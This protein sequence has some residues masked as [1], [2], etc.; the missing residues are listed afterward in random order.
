MLRVTGTFDT[1]VADPEKSKIC[2]MVINTNDLLFTNSDFTDGGVEIEEY[3]CT[4]NDLTYGDTPS[5]RLTFSVFG[6]GIPDGYSFFTSDTGNPII[7]MFGVE[8]ASA[9]YTFGSG[10]L[11]HI[12]VNDNGTTRVV[13]GKTDGLYYNG[14]KIDNGVYNTLLCNNAGNFLALPQTPDPV[15]PQYALVDFDGN[16]TDIT[17]NDLNA[18]MIRKFANGASWS[19]TDGNEAK[20]WADGSVVTYEL[21]SGGWFDCEIKNVS[22]TYVGNVYTFSDL[23]GIMSRNDDVTYYTYTP[24]QVVAYLD[25]EDA[26]KFP[27]V[28]YPMTLTTL[29]D[30]LNY[31][32]PESIIVD[33]L[34]YENLDAAT[35]TALKNRFNNISFASNPFHGRSI[36]FRQIL[37]WIGQITRTVA[38][39]SRASGGAI[40]PRWISI[41]GDRQHQQWDIAETVNY[42]NIASS[43]ISL[44]YTTILPVC[45]MVVEGV[46]GT[47][48]DYEYSGT[49][50][51][52]DKY[53]TYYIG[54]NPMIT[55]FTQSNANDYLDGIPN[56]H[57]CHFTVIYANPAVEVGDTIDAYCVYTGQVDAY[58]VPIYDDIIFPLMHRRMVFN[59]ICFAAEYEASGGYQRE[60]NEMYDIQNS[61]TR[62]TND[63]SDIQNAGYLTAATGVTSVNGNHGAVTVSDT[64]VTQTYAT[65]S[66]YT[67]WRP[68]VIGYSSGSSESFTPST[69]TNSVYTFSTLKVQ[70]S[71]GTIKATTFKGDLTGTASGNLTSSS[72]LDPT[73][74]SG[75]STGTTKFLREDGTW[76]TPAYPPD[77]STDVSN[78][79]TILGDFLGFKRVSMTANSSKSLT[80]KNASYS[81]C[82][83]IL[84]GYSVGTKGLYIVTCT[85]SG[86][87]SVVAV[88]AGANLSYTTSSYTLTFT[89]SSTTNACYIE[90]MIFAGDVT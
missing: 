51:N 23:S 90:I 60:S 75:V 17:M 71:S 47:V 89:N 74:L 9:S 25:D 26:G 2:F 78:I 66:S 53:S 14:T 80:F 57:P 64:K 77:L 20:V 45:R 27:P 73:K 49:K 43:D 61:I 5:S 41:D 52:P 31:L 79:Q 72:T 56:Y 88:S 38:V 59:G 6:E 29:C 11:A 65:A 30:T 46:D 42:S 15:T 39:E 37:S 7:P 36:N 22:K 55:S 8:V 70:P 85:N 50:P 58:G 16:T 86:V 24:E 62:N 12:E 1:N 76:Q 35:R 28:Q 84:D 34:D 13:E 83:L 18:F 67:Y 68:L 81:R 87:L 32:I 48:W 82:L 40:V 19:R 3:F 44:A 54:G 69:Q 4:S 63:I 21:I 33:A 10:V